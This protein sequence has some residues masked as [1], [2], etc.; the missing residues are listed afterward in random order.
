MAQWIDELLPRLR[1][2]ESQGVE[3]L[4]ELQELATAVKRL[5]SHP[6][7]LLPASSISTLA[8]L[9]SSELETS[10]SECD[11]P[12]E[13]FVFLT[14]IDAI[15]DLLSALITSLSDVISE[16]DVLLLSRLELGPAW[17]DFT[18][19]LCTDWTVLESLSEDSDSLMS[20]ESTLR[21]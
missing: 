6:Q 19:T 12:F 2:L 9:K 11:I 1:A 16:Y 14:F 10:P 5:Q 18:C 8:L 17:G 4:Q 7:G 21:A 20:G 15:F 3:I 13:F